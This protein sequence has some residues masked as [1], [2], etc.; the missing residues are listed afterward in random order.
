[1]P[2]HPENSQT[3]SRPHRTLF[4]R[5]AAFMSPEPES[6]G[7]LLDILHDAHTRKLIDAECLSMIEGVFQVNELAARDLMV[8]RA[9]IYAI[10]ITRPVNEWLAE[11]I[12]SGH[13]RF[14]A[15]E[16]DLDKVVG[17]I[18]TKDLLA[19]F[20]EKEFDLAT[21][22]RP[23]VFIPESK[24]AN[25]LLRDF[26]S[27]RNHMALVVDEYGSIAGLITIEDVLEEIVGEIEDEYD[28]DEDES[29]IRI[30]KSGDSPAWRVSAL[31]ELADFNAAIGAELDENAADTLGGYIANTLGSLPHTGDVFDIEGLH[32][33]V[34]RA[35]AR[36]LH[37]LLVEK[38]A[39]P[40]AQANALTT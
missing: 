5:L 4:E 37:Y 39:A 9:Q 20:V 16:G 32:F 30:I 28:D 10:D 17:I 11:I 19:Y 15:I 22:I 14:P 23:A 33:V 7:E 40:S 6:R 8:P 26:R 12:E 25:V 29:E 27:N 13:S 31:I 35:D 34:L 3:V 2:E 21:I 38:Y 36:Q 1:M 24:R 18:L